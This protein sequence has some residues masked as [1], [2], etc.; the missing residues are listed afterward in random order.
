VIWDETSRFHDR[1]GIRVT[2]ETRERAD[3]VYSER[4]AQVLAAISS[5]LPPEAFADAKYVNGVWRDLR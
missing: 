1:V 3:K 4:R 2:A 5:G